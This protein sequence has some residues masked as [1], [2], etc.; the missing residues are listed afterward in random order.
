ML[1]FFAD[2]EYAQPPELYDVRDEDEDV[3]DSDNLEE[4][5]SL[6]PSWCGDSPM[7]V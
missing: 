7:L 3:D 6:T 2:I 5:W 1:A 4:R